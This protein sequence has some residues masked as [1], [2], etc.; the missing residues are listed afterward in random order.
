MG[1]MNN[2]TTSISE[3]INEL[4]SLIINKPKAY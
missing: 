1:N 3:N 2:V 4:K